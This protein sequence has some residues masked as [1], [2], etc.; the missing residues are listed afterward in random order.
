MTINALSGLSGSIQGAGVPG[1]AGG[2]GAV[3]DKEFL[4]QLLKQLL[5]ASNEKDDLSGLLD[6]LASQSADDAKGSSAC[7]GAGAANAGN[8]AGA[9]GGSNGGGCDSGCGSNGAQAAQT[10]GVA[11]GPQGLGGSLR[12]Q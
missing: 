11:A 8:G 1:A 6:K 3:D 5:N 2:A 9:N 7:S 10:A 4:A 12:F